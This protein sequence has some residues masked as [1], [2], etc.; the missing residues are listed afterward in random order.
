MCQVGLAIPDVW[1]CTGHLAL[2]F[3]TNS[4]LLFDL[5]IAFHGQART[6]PI[7]LAPCHCFIRIAAFITQDLAGGQ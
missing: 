5:R 2:L 7:V 3:P 1:S 6:L 4:P